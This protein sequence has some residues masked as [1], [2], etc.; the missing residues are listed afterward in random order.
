MT[1]PNPD[2]PAEAVLPPRGD[3][4]NSGESAR[5]SGW[6]FIAP[7]VIALVLLIAGLIL[8]YPAFVNFSASQPLRDGGQASTGPQ[9]TVIAAWVITSITEQAKVPRSSVRFA[10]K[11][12][13]YGDKLDRDAL[14]ARLQGAFEIPIDEEN[15]R[16]WDTVEDVIRTVESKHPAKTP[17]PPPPPRDP[18][19]AASKPGG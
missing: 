19:P 16:S 15:V 18:A 4:T 9:R 13:D 1:D 5:G 6:R 14:A 3:T 7:I 8:G 17:P 10:S 12:A 2:S 11:L